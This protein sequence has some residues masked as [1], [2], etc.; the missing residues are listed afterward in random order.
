MSAPDPDPAPALASA[1][2]DC[3]FFALVQFWVFSGTAPPLFFAALY[4]LQYSPI[5]LFVRLLVPFLH[6]HGCMQHLLPS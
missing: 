3:C 5:Q 2:P 4:D 6:L 1:C